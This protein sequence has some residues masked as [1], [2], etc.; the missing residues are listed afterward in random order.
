MMYLRA[1]DII[2]SNQDIRDFVAWAMR[3]TNEG[4][5]RR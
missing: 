1:E 5:A 4:P 3:A 2:T